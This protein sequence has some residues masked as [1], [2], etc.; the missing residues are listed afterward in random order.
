MAKKSF[1]RRVEPSR[2]RTREIDWPFPVE[3]DRPRVKMRVLGSTEMEAAYLAVVDYFKAKKLK[4]A[5]DD[6]AFIKRERVELVLR[7]FSA[8][9]EPIADTADELAAEPP[10]VIGTLY[11]EWDAFQTDV[12][13]APMNKGEMDALVE[14]LKKNTQA[15]PLHAL[16]LSWLI[17]LISTLASQP[18]TSTQANEG[19]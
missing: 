7:A 15:V 10:E 19:G 12:T 9:G 17:E 18:V 8:D 16:P 1:L 13:A 3:G 5:V 11:R 4:V 6:V 14:A 2:A